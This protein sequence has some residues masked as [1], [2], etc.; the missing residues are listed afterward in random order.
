MYQVSDVFVKKAPANC[1]KWKCRS[2]GIPIIVN[3][4]YTYLTR[5][6][7]VYFF[8]YSCHGR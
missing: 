3:C 1:I 2:V 5:I 6:H 8:D 7:L 4:V